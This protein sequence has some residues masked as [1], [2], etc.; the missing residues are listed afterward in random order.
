MRVKDNLKIASVLLLVV[1]GA[2]IVG[3]FLAPHTVL[4]P[5]SVTV[6]RQ[7]ATV[8]Q[9]ILGSMDHVQIQDDGY[10]AFPAVYVEA[11]QTFKVAW[12]SLDIFQRSF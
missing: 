6:P 2:F 5:Q 4:A 1:G 10:Y 11:G 8:H 7:V 3:N 12:D 9:T